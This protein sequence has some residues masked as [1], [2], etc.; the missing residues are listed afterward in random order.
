MKN[1]SREVQK[2]PEKNEE[3]F[4]KIEEVA[5][6]IEGESENNGVESGNQVSR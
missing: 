6:Q 2:N 4:A 5:I 1:A 3:D